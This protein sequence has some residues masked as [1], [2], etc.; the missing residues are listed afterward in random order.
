MASKRRERSGPAESVVGAP[1]KLLNDPEIQARIERARERI[2]RG[3]TSSGTS[4]DQLLEL[5]RERRRERR[6]DP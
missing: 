3:E 2:R 1:A 6:V 5:A 4:A